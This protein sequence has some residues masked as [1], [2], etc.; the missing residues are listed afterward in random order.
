MSSN[1]P[2][3]CGE[4]LLANPEGMCLV[5]ERSPLGRAAALLARCSPPALTPALSQVVEG[6]CILRLLLAGGTPDRSPRVF[7]RFC[8]TQW[9]LQ[10]DS[11]AYSTSPHAPIRISVYLSTS[12]E[13]SRSSAPAP[14]CSPGSPARADP[15]ASPPGPLR[16]VESL[17]LVGYSTRSVRSNQNSPDPAAVAGKAAPT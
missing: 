9:A 15:P 6:M 13:L 7:F 16:V 8:P 17:H 1:D 10:Q 14:H 5:G 11:G 2:R 12:S 3:C 4:P